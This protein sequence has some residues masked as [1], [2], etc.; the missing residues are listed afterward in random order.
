MIIKAETIQPFDFGGLTIFDLTAALNTR[1]S[2]ARIQVPPHA[3]H[4][5]AWSVECDKYYYVISGQ[6]QFML[7]ELEYTLREGDLCIVPQGH[8]FSYV[9]TT[10]AAVE[11]LLIHTPTFNPDAEIFE[12]ER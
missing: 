6:L 1:S 10:V 12:E 4:P 7:E 2:L 9:N 3:C 5:R 11:L 8:K